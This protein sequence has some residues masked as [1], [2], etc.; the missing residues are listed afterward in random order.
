MAMAEESA[1]A[2]PMSV[3]SATLEPTAA[4]IVAEPLAIVRSEPVAVSVSGPYGEGL[5]AGAVGAL[6]IALWFMVV[7]IADGHPLFTPNLLGAALFGGGEGLTHAGKL[8]I[9]L[10]LVLPFTWVHLLIF[11]GIGVAAS[12]LLALAERDPDFGFGV[13]LLFVVFEFGFVAAC[14]LFAEPVLHAL[15][16]TGV[17]VGNLLAA[18]A[19]TIVF[20]R[21]HPRLSIAP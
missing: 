1:A 21:R 16:W 12:Q 4:P 2:F 9:S 20:W 13:L 14:M 17:L 6:T 7:D 15:T 10:D 8:P 5:L 11:L 19:M 3:P 18:V